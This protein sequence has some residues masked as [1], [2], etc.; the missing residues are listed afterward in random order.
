MFV[1]HGM[2]V[3]ALFMISLMMPIFISIDILT[4]KKYNFNVNFLYIKNFSR[5]TVYIYDKKSFVSV[6]FV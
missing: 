1:V 6:N 5:R 2:A 3:A 4:E